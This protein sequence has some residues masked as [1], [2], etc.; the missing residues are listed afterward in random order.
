MMMYAVQPFPGSLVVK[1]CVV[2]TAQLLLLG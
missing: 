1:W 2:I